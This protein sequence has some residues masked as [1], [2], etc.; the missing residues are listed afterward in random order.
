M[1]AATVI[2][3]APHRT[4]HPSVC[5]SVAARQPSLRSSRDR[6]FFWYP[7]AAHRFPAIAA[8][9]CL[10]VLVEASTVESNLASAQRHLVC[11]RHRRQRLLASAPPSIPPYS[12]VQYLAAPCAGLAYAHAQA[13]HTSCTSAP[14]R[15]GTPARLSRLAAR[16]SRESKSLT[17]S[18][19]SVL[20]RPRR[21][22]CS[23]CFHRLRHTRTLGS[24]G[25]H[26]PRAISV[27]GS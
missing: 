8:S 12:P 21:D 15:L 24:P 27:G 18:Y 7:P 3:T 9:C 26:C 6:R 4:L 5:P 25:R 16:Y 2:T 1:P 13:T 22:T 11:I 23:R 17:P 10:L 14:P 20:A 19:A